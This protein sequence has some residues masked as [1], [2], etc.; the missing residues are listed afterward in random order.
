MH[1]SRSSKGH[2]SSR[3]PHHA[4]GDDSKQW[5]ALAPSDDQALVLVSEQKR[6]RPR[7][8]RHCLF[9]FHPQ[10]NYTLQDELT[11]RPQLL[12]H[13]AAQVFCT[14]RVTA[15]SCVL[16]RQLQIGVQSMSSV[17]PSGSEVYIRRSWF[18][19]DARAPRTLVQVVSARA[20]V[21]T[22]ILPTY[23]P[24]GRALPHGTFG[25]I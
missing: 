24:K 17:R 22:G 2:F 15:A 7:S 4:L 3:T 6:F 25:H 20:S 12:Q 8:R 13:A 18:C 14:V 5:P 19:S 9:F 11:T 23:A 10:H 21:D 1:C 16:Q